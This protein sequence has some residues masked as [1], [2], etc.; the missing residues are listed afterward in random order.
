MNIIWNLKLKKYTLI[1]KLSLYILSLYVLVACLANVLANDKPIYCNCNGVMRWPALREYLEQ[2]NILSTTHS[3]DY[4]NCSHKLN[5]IIPYSAN[6]L[7]PTSNGFAP[8]FYRSSPDN[9]YHILGTDAL[10][11]DVLA[12]LIHGTRYA[13]YIG[14]LSTILA[15]IPG[16]LLGMIMGYFQN[17]KIRWNLCQI[18]SLVIWIFVGLY[19]MYITPHIFPDYSFLVQLTCIGVWFF[20]AYFLI[21]IFSK[22]GKKYK[23]P[24]DNIL[25]RCIDVFES[26]PKLLLL[27]SLIVIYTRPSTLLLIFLIAILRWPLF[28]QIARAETL[29]ECQSNYIISSENLGVSVYLILTKHIWP[30]IKGSLWVTALFSFSSA[31]L[32]EATLSFIGIGLRLEQVSWGS[33]L[34]EGRQYLPGWWLSVFPGL[35]IF[36][37]LLTINWLFEENSLSGN[38]TNK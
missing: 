9:A 7:D 25:M 27:M 5:S 29:K 36:T 31:I 11:K 10:G 28:A 2:I 32:L 19:E 16:I 20:L 21:K 13:F 18:L 12:G 37:L 30:N 1:Q 3:F 33:L 26:F 22:F 6:S 24:I 34:N 38:P 17:Y 23:M 15:F 14:I 4:A 8:P 35:A